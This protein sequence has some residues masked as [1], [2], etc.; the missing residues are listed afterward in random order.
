MAFVTPATPNLADFGTFLTTSVQIPT[1]ALPTSSPWIG[2]AFTQAMEMILTPPNTI[3]VVYS[4]AVYNGAT[5]LL[6]LITPDQAGQT[7][8]A[9]ARSNIASTNFP[10][11][12]FGLNL[13]QVGLVTSTFDQGTG[14]T[15]V[16]PDW[17]KG[18]TIGQLGF[19]STPYGRTFLQWNMSYGSTIV[20]LT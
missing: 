17:A 14:T 2:Y 18:L 20:G 11:G 3:G 13:P 10:N 12:G 15:V 9:D 16:S 7:Y 6:F 5:H 8:F 1:A 19:M 4:L